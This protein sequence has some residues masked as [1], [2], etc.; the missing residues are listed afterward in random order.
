MKMKN[1]YCVVA[2]I[3]L[4]ATGMASAFT[5]PFVGKWVLNPRLSKYP[6]DTCP[7]GMVI[8]MESAGEGVHYRSDT[9]YANGV[10]AHSEYTAEYN[11]RQSL[12]TGTRGMLLPVSLNRSSLRVVL[13]SYTRG[14]QVVATSRRVISK[15]GL[16]MTITTTSKDRSGAA[17]LTVGVYEKQRERQ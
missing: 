16:R 12:V 13:A 17:V 7:R 14:L 6:G 5:D 10:T 8:E 3:L 9:M 4:L 2:L 11:G 1:R 15:D